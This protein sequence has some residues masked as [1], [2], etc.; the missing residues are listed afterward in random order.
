MDNLINSPIDQELSKL[1]PF[2]LKG[3]IIELADEKV[4]KAA[5][6]MLNAG[7]GNPNWVADVPRSAFFAFG[8][9]A[10]TECARNFPCRRVWLEFR[11]KKASLRVLKPGCAIMLI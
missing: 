5:N 9:F 1:S 7:R 8:Q 10:M 11:K 2:E 4:K 3:K 6:T